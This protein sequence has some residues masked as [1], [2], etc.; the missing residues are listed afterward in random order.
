MLYLSNYAYFKIYIFL[1]VVGERCIIWAI[2][3]SMFFDNLKYNKQ[4]IGMLCIGW[5][6][7]WYRS[8]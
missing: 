4:C 1:A 3:Q 6:A 7:V 8:F 5:W 2:E